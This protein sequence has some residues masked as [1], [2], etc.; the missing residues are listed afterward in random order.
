MGYFLDGANKNPAGRTDED[1]LV[2]TVSV[3]ESEF[4]YHSDVKGEAYSWNF[5]TYN[6]GVGDTLALIKNTSATKEL[7]IDTITVSSDVESVI[8]IHLP[9]TEVTPAGT[10]V[11]GVNLN[12]RSTNVAPATAMTDETDN[13]QGDIIF[14]TEIQA[15]GD[16]FVKDYAGVLILGQNKSVGLDGVADMGAFNVTIE[17]HFTNNREIG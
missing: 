5:L 3:V 1:G 13:S 4:E 11:T 17:G 2:K 9:T 6:M 16:P 8:T 15:A 10:A 14:Q 7:H 12:T